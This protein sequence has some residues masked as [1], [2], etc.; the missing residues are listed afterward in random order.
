MMI[1]DMASGR[2]S[3]KYGFKGVNKAVLSAGRY[4]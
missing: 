1:A 4:A 3:M 2:I